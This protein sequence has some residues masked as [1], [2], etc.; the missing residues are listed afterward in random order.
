MAV[1]MTYP[2]VR[3]RTGESACLQRV[4][5]IRVAQLVMDYLSYGWSADEMIRQHPAL[6]PA[7]V[8]AAMAYYYDHREEIDGEIRAEWKECERAKASRPHS[9]LALRLL[10]KQRK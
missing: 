2:H 3:K 4:P 7:E 1:R 6:Q 8:H 10:A 5:R 9:V